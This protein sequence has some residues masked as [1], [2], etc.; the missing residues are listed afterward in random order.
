MRKACPG[1]DVIIILTC[2]LQY[3][4]N[5]YGTDMILFILFV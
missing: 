1:Y 3:S 5:D 2:Q 4:Y